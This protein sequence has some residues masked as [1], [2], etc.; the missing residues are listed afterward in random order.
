MARR[1]EVEIVGDASSYQRALGQAQSKTSKFGAVA[2]TA[3]IGGAAAGMY[4]LGKAAKLGWDEFNAGQR[5]AA[6]TAAVLKSTGGAANVTAKHVQDMG[7]RLME[8]SGI[9]DE[10]IVQGENML[11]TFRDIRNE[12]GKG[13]DIFDRATELTLDLATAMHTDMRSAAIQVGKALNDPIRGYSRLQR[14]GVDFSDAQI[15]QIETF[16]AVGK[17]MEAQK[18]ILRELSKEFGGSAKAMGETFGG[19]LNILRERLNNFLGLIVGKAIP[20]L[21][22]LMKWVGPRLTEASERARA[23]W[24]EL[25]AVLQRHEK[26]INQVQR[27]LGVLVRV[28]GYLV[29]WETF[30]YS[31]IWKVWMGILRV[32]LT[33]T[34]KIISAIQKIAGFLR[35]LGGAARTAGNV[36]ATG[37][38]I[39]LSPILTVVNAVQRLID[40]IQSIPVV[41]SIGSGSGSDFYS[42][43]HAP[44]R[45]ATGGLIRRSGL[46]TV[47]RGERLQPASIV[48]HNAQLA[49]GGSVNVIVL[50]GDREAI[51]YLRQLDARSG[52]RSGRGIL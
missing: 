33:V 18:V 16:D 7:N 19:Q 40:L 6:Q 46:M 13:N 44:P 48:R 35:A 8:L 31:T 15:K 28:L 3:L 17:K 27:A 47:H 32:T 41:G 11:L 50:G 30:L 45:G 37:F 43:G 49:G 25:G 51:N 26:T 52:R 2:K 38:R 23:A 10:L 24:I 42:G 34:D 4:A 14:I 9:D 29:R 36:V 21:Q 12:V 20:Y 22:R 39:M 1:I 5:E